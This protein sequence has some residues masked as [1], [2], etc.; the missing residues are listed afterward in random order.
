M[1]KATAMGANPQT[2]AN[3]LRRRLLDDQQELRHYEP[4]AVKCWRAL[5]AGVCDSLDKIAVSF[6]EMN[7]GMMAS[8][9]VEF[10]RVEIEATAY[11]HIT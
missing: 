3:E 7:S 2:V 9:S 6:K 1:P 4:E 8:V 5:A 11:R 10:G